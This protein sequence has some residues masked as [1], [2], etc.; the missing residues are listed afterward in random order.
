M[1]L[2]DFQ[3]KD[4]EPIDKPIIQ[5]D[6]AKIYQQQGPNLNDSNQNIDFI[7]GENN[8]YHQIGIAYIEFDITVRDSAGNS[9]NASAIRL[10]NNAFAC[11]FKQTTLATTGGMGLEDIKYVGQVSKTMR[12]LT[13]KDSD[14]SSCFDKN[15]EK[16]LNNNNPSKEILI[17]NHAE[18][19]NKGKIKGQLPLEHIFGFCK[20]FK[21]IEKSLGF[22]VT[23]KMNDLQDIIFTTIATDI[24]VAINSFYLYVPISIP[25]SQ[26]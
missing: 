19:K 20:T 6:C 26:T 8:N 16:A 17:N 13:S 14:L 7:F 11:R 2:E 1:S 22:H 15:A 23:F 25:N 10:V 9:T 4:N 21:K 18:E 12:L 3:L 24:N 5:R